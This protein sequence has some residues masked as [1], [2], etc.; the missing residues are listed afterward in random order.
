MA[1]LAAAFD[2]FDHSVISVASGFWKSG[3]MVQALND[4]KP[5]PTANA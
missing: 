4:S 3:P 5:S 1:W 2:G